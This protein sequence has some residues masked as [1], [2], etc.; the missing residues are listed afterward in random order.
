MLVSGEVAGVFNG[1]YVTVS[2]AEGDVLQVD[3]TR[4]ERPFKIEVLDVSREVA[5]PQPGLT[6][7]V[8]ESLGNIALVRLSK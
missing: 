7:T 4:Y 6:I 1:R 3:G 5:E 2:V 8:N